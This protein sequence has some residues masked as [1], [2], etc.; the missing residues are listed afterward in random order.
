MTNHY[1]TI[2]SLHNLCWRVQHVVT[3]SMCTYT[4]Q[5]SIFKRLCKVLWKPGTGFTKQ[6]IIDSIS[7][8]QSVYHS[9][10]FIPNTAEKFVKNNLISPKY[11][12]YNNSTCSSLV[13]KSMIL[14]VLCIFKHK[15]SIMLGKVFGEMNTIFCISSDD[16]ACYVFGNQL[17]VYID[18]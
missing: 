18:I 11:C 17:K 7:F 3:Y 5:G 4:S 15:I 12:K 13:L 8:H 10:K 16:S 14:K 9:T 1:I 6:A 2:I